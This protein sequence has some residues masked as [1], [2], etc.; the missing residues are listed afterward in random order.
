MIDNTSGFRSV[1]ESKISGILPATNSGAP[2]LALFAR[3]GK[4]TDFDGLSLK[5]HQRFQELVGNS[6]EFPTSR[7]KREIWG[8]RV[9]GRENS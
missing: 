2:Y 1:R 6:R 9:R 5:V 8:T 4:N 7:K 3:C